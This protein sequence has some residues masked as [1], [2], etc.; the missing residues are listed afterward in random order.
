MI[1]LVWM[2]FV[3]VLKAVAASL[4]IVLSGR[5]LYRIA[6]RKRQDQNKQKKTTE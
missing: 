4:S 2:E 3:Y 1:V 6:R 5:K